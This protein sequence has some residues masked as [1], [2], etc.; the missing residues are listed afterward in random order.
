[1]GYSFYFC[2]NLLKMAIPQK[3]EWQNQALCFLDY[4]Q[5]VDS[6]YV[7]DLEDYQY[8]LNVERCEATPEMI[9]QASQLPMGATECAVIF[10]ERYNQDVF[11][12]FQ[13]DEYLE[14]LKIQ[15]LIKDLGLD[16]EKFW[17]LILFV[18]DYCNSMFYEGIT[19][20]MTPF[21]QL[22]RLIDN[23]NSDD[24]SALILK[25]G[26]NQISVNHPDVIKFLID[27]IVEKIEK[28]D[29]EY[30]KSLF[31]R[32]KAENS[33]MLKESPFIAYFSKMLLRFFDTQDGV[34]KQRRKGAKHSQKE[35]ELVCRLIYFTKIST[36]KVWLEDFDLLKSYL[37]QYRNYKYPNNV[38]SIYPE[39][40]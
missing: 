2:G 26:K 32:E 22:E 28:S 7:P 36:N 4:I 16:V 24:F 33:I 19:M 38:S 8:K 31:S 14:N 20:A 39:F 29:K 40:E 10:K 21:E 17:F 30:I 23:M 27:A 35:R 5:I 9:E 1:M 6:L 25:T 18:F 11:K 15:N 12:R 13:F 34:R 37:K 3:L